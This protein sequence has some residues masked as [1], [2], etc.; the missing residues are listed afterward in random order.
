[1]T[2]KDIELLFQSESYDEAM[3]L[4]RKELQEDSENAEWYYYLFLAENGDYANINFEDVVCEF[5][6]N[7]ALDLANARLRELFLAEY[8]FY[9]AVD[10]ALRKY[11]AY[12]SRGNID[13]FEALLN[14]YENRATKLIHDSTSKKDFYSN[15]DYLVTSRVKHEIVDL[16]ILSLNLL[17]LSIQNKKVL[18]IYNVLKE[19]AEEIG[20]TLANAPLANNL[21]EIKEYMNTIKANINI[22]KE[23]E[24]KRLE[25]KVLAKSLEKKKDN[26]NKREEKLLE[27]KALAKSLE[28]ENLNKREEK[29]L[30]AKALLNSKEYELKRQ[31]EI[32]ENKKAFFQQPEVKENKP[33]QDTPIK[34]ED[35]NEKPGYYKVG[36]IPLKYLSLIMLIISFC[37]FVA[38]VN[39]YASGY[40]ASDGGILGVYLLVFSIPVSFATWYAFKSQYKR[41]NGAYPSLIFDLLTILFA[42]IALIVGIVSSI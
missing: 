20:T 7:R 27:A 15:L 41:V 1:M 42:I 22:S 5:D 34:K 8:N 39:V 3:R 35:S 16:N 2:R 37:D 13:K 40:E 30:K 19:R 33:I 6:F 32:E 24:R 18:E 4:L 36:K 25:L 29:L 9:K 26:L 38:T 21:L 14:T 11:F 31:K 10:P 23:E 28:K 12:A 17:Y